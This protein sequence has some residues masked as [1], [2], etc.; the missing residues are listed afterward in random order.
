M[1]VR[2][3]KWILIFAGLLIAGA[4]S[5]ALADAAW[6]DGGQTLGDGAGAITNVAWGDITGTLSA[7]SDLNIQLTNRYTRSEA[8]AADG[9]TPALTTEEVEDIAGGMV[10]GSEV[11]L[12]VAYNDPAGTLEF[13]QDPTNYPFP[14]FVLDIDP[15]REGWTD[16]ELKASHN[17]FTDVIYHYG[18]TGTND[19]QCN[20]SHYVDDYDPYVYYTA[21]GGH[22][23]GV[24]D[25]RYWHRQV[26]HEDM[27]TTLADA[28]DG[29]VGAVVF[30]PSKSTA[31]TEWQ[32]VLRSA[33]NVM[34]SWIRVDVSGIETNA[35][36][37]PRWMTIE[38]AGWVAAR[39]EW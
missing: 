30:Y 28:S 5:N 23:N 22:T 10:D 13:A 11:G 31:C 14:Y 17:N 2:M 20:D 16:F 35:G 19:T 1:E 26:P 3:N 39:K 4:Y 21:I 12:V 27:Y 33:T 29:L 8:D 37:D 7:Q 18:S 6:A 24:V 15:V 36:G 38:P 9:D 25:E 34:Y 32:A